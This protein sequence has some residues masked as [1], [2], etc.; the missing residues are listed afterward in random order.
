MCH[1]QNKSISIYVSLLGPFILFQCPVDMSFIN[2]CELFGQ[3]KKLATNNGPNNTIRC[4][5]LKSVGWRTLRSNKEA[6]IHKIF[7]WLS[8]KPPSPPIQ[9][10]IIE[11]KMQQNQHKCFKYTWMW[12]PHLNGIYSIH[13]FCWCLCFVSIHTIEHK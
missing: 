5:K 1:I 2:C 11:N 8:V 3:C 9:F 12:W 10:C 7:V 6:T 4:S 13:W